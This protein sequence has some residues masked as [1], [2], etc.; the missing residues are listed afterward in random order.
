MLLPNCLSLLKICVLVLGA[1]AN[2]ARTYP[3][4][5]NLARASDATEDTPS[6]SANAENFLGY[7]MG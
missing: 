3:L 2:Q 7:K 4:K 6:S 5:R 1:I